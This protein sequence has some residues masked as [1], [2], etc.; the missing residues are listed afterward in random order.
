MIE[1]DT[2]VGSYFRGVER[3]TGN[4]FSSTVSTKLPTPTK[5]LQ[6]F[7]STIMIFE[8]NSQNLL[9]NN[10]NAEDKTVEKINLELPEKKE[11]MI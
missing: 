5:E 6:N 8:A 7:S 10:G 2:Q 4:Q 3:S 9:N 1:K 11:S